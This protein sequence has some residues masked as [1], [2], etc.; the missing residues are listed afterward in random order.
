M[1]KRSGSAI[2]SYRIDMQRIIDEF[3]SSVSNSFIAESKILIPATESTM[4]RRG[5]I[6]EHQGKPE[7]FEEHFKQYKAELKDF[8]HK[9]DKRSSLYEYPFKNEFLEISKW[10]LYEGKYL[11]YNYEL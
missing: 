5:I 8:A 11:N 7:E 4:A 10:E 3:N 2:G 1:A 9:L 6:V